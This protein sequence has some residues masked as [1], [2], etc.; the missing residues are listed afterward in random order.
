[1]ECSKR[2]AVVCIEGMKS[3]IVNIANRVIQ[4]WLK[5]KKKE[6]L[7]E[8]WNAVKEKEQN[9]KDE[10]LQTYQVPKELELTVK[11]IFEPE[12]EYVLPFTEFF[13]QIEPM[14]MFCDILYLGQRKVEDLQDTFCGIDDGRT[15]D[16]SLEK[17]LRKVDEIRQGSGSSKEPVTKKTKSNNNNSFEAKL[18]KV[19]DSPDRLEGK[20]DSEETSLKRTKRIVQETRIMSG[21]L[22]TCEN[23]KEVVKEIKKLGS[24]WMTHYKW[25]V[26]EMHEQTS[27]CEAEG[28]S[29]LQ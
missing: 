10:I 21:D 19:L 18:K 26:V 25:N 8:I 2:S 7:Q 9:L 4:R 3:V 22:A 5:D 28:L 24:S 11:K 14:K 23:C 17:D 15:N 16:E 6:Q 20:V 13:C 29:L 12:W 27:F 1:M